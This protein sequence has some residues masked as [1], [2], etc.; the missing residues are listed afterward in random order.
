MVSILQSDP[1][2][3]S[4]CTEH[5]PAELER[6]VS[7]ALQKDREQRYQTADEFGAD[8]YKLAQRLELDVKPAGAIVAAGSR[9]RF[10]RRPRAASSAARIARGGKAAYVAAVL[11][12]AGLVGALIALNGGPEPPSV[13]AEFSDDF[14]VFNP[15]RWN[16]PA[17]GWVVESGRLQL[18]RAAVI[19]FPKNLNNR[20]F[21]ATFHLKLINAGGA[22]WAVRVRDA[23]NYYLFYLS[24]PEG[25]FPPA[26]FNTYIVRNGRFDPR[27]HVESVAAIVELRAQGE[28]QVE[29]I[30]RDN[31]LEHRIT[32]AETGKR[33]T[34]G[35][36]KDVGD[37]FPYGGIGF[38]T[39][40]PEV[41]S[42]DEL[43]VLTPGALS[44]E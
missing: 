21:A 5:A 23:A 13:F 36:F 6:I 9:P 25:L 35:S 14:D 44:D 1:K 2:S 28:Y 22:A 30:A 8:L 38:R 16:V 37:V 7:R 10:R 39:V 26:R 20:D 42:V 4:D 11:A 41:F 24:G 31:V 40:G 19:G 29:I 18:D 33:I 27:D 12:A 34:L 15:N 43:Y 3:L 32:P 17:T